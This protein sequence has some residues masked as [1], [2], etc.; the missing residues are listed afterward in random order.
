[1]GELEIAIGPA[2]ADVRPEFEHPVAE[3]IHDFGVHDV[4]YIV[5]INMAPPCPPPMHSVAMPRLS[6]KRFIALTRCSTMR[7]PLAPT[8]CPVPIAPPSILSL[9]RGIA[10]AGPSSPSTLRQTSSSCHAARQ[11]STCAA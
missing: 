1:M 5:S 9:S 3:N 10:P 4:P 8:G 7:L 2:L 6:P 11:P